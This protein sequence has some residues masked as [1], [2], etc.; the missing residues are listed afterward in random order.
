[1]KQG[2]RFSHRTLQSVA[3][4]VA[5][6]GKP[7]L[8]S[9]SERFQAALG[10]GGRRFK[11]GH[12]DKTRTVAQVREFTLSDLNNFAARTLIRCGLLLFFVMGLNGLMGFYRVLGREGASYVHAPKIAIRFVL[13]RS[14]LPAMPMLSKPFSYDL[15]PPRRHIHPVSSINTS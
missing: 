1:L 15:C 9:C 7:P 12:P 4:E 14:Y 8:P 5:T 3:V 13:R 2:D 10:A 11:S 6:G